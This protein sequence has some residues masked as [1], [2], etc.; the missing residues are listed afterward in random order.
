[1]SEPASS[2]RTARVPV[3]KIRPPLSEREIRE[4]LQGLGVVEQPYLH[5]LAREKFEK[6]QEL[7][8]G[9][10]GE[11]AVYFTR[12]HVVKV[13]PQFSAH[14][15]LREVA[16]LLLLNR[17]ADQDSGPGERARQ[18]WPSVL[19]IYLLSDG[20]LAFGMHTFDDPDFPG[21]G[22]TLQERL[23]Q[24]PPISG[25]EALRIARSLPESLL[26]AH[27]V[28]VIHHDLKPENVFLP[29]DPRRPVVIFDLGQALLRRGAWGEE[30]LRHEH[31]A[32]HWYN[33]TPHYM[34]LER[35]KAHRAALA[36]ASGRLPLPERIQ[37]V[38]AYMPSLYDDVFAYA[39]IL[40]RMARSPNVNWV[41]TERA[42]LRDF[43][44][45]L[46]GLR[47]KTRG[48]SSI[49]QRISATVVALLR[50][51]KPPAGTGATSSP[52]AQWSDFQKV[53]TELDKVLAGL[54]GAAG[55]TL[56]NAPAPS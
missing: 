48:R 55:R 12:G 18:D 47:P 6:E 41:E 42:A 45:R 7:E 16:H 46:M 23:R 44:R 2:D 35:R 5:E 19:W 43:S 10:G 29:N 8:L 52:Q 20:S 53:L 33:G 51:G 1:M 25:E 32:S 9:R 11:G 38:A 31:N 37:A 13:L 15:G 22:S 54:R 24:G 50:A 39:R 40:R 49:S 3:S 17:P 30:W 56:P 14:D 26:F 36:L 21:S 4:T 34:H 27:S 28:G